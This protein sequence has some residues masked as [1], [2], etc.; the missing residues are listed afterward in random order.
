MNVVCREGCSSAN[1][2][3]G[4]WCDLGAW[5]EGERLWTGHG[6]ISEVLLHND[7]FCNDCVTKRCIILLYVPKQSTWLNGAVT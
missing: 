5:A 2:P 1:F 4:N 6:A 7:R 3:V